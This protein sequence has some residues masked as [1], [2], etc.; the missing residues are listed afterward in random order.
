[1]TYSHALQKNILLTVLLYSPS[2]MTPVWAV[3]NNLQFSGMLVSDPC[4]LDPNTT[5]LTVE[6]TSIIEKDIYLN[7][8][9]SAI[10]FTINLI[11]CDTSLGSTVTFSFKG[12]ESAALPGYLKVEGSA[13]GI[14]I[15][16]KNDQGTP[17][18]F[19]SELPPIS[20]SD[21]ISSI[22][23]QAYVEGEPEAI[24]NKT[25]IP[26]DFSATATFELAYP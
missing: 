14:A 26:G 16:M 25:I 18:P 19:N 8:R 13:S 4:E 23:V 22:T 12:I 7:T 1:M 20:L 17:L 21:G 15:G 9:A 5:D 2:I 6:F 10:P 24:Q 3:D 11:N